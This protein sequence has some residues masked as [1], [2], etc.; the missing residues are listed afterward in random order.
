[1]RSTNIVAALAA[2]PRS[3]DSWEGESEPLRDL[4][5]G[6]GTREPKLV[7]VQLAE[8]YRCKKMLA[9]QCVATSVESR[10]SAIQL[11]WCESRQLIV[12]LYNLGG[13]PEEKGSDPPSLAAWK[14]RA[15]SWIR[16]GIEVAQGVLWLE[17]CRAEGEE[18]VPVGRVSL[19]LALPTAVSCVVLSPIHPRPPKPTKPRLSLSCVQVSMLNHVASHLLCIAMA[20]G[21]AHHCWALV[22]EVLALER[23][24]TIYGHYYHI[25]TYNPRV[26]SLLGTGTGEGYYHIWT[27]LPYMDV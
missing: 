16:R 18:H 6:C 4:I 15:H 23:V 20:T 22:M 8:N 27:L 11:I 13:S 25:W 2:G 10:A 12:A 1:M 17:R 21:L 19:R 14:I 3:N 26:Y 24:I 7:A 5:E 9:A